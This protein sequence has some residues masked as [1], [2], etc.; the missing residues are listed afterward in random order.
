MM[1]Y[2]RD[3]SCYNAENRDGRRGA[4]NARRPGRNTL[5]VSDMPQPTTPSTT[6]ASR[7]DVSLALCECG[8]GQPAPIA[9]WTNRRQG[10]VRG[11]PLR[12]VHGHNHRNRTGAK[13][14]MWGKRREQ[15]SGWKG[16]RRIVDGYVLIRRPDHPR[17]CGGYVFEHILVAEQMLGR[18]L[19]PGEEVHHRDENRSNNSPT[20]LDVKPSRA[21]H[22]YEHRKPTSRRRLPDE[23]NPLVSCAC[24][25]GGRFRRYDNDRRPRRFLVGHARRGKRGDS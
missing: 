3:F 20:N 13:N 9:R 1:L 10:A 23:P 21:H 19:E 24:G 17:A 8:C 25:C 4:A 7:T 2:G 12:F 15:A 16:G 22:A 5:E 14:P 6:P 11:H 18:P